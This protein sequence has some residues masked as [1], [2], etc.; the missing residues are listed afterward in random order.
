[1]GKIHGEDKAVEKMMSFLEM[2]VYI[3]IASIAIVGAAVT[4]T[5]YRFRM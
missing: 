5:I 2:L 1:M 3:G 4:Y